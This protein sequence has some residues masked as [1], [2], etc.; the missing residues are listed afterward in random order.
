VARR[1][2]IL[3]QGAAGPP[4]VVGRALIEPGSLFRD[5]PEASASERFEDLFTAATAAG[6]TRIERIVSTGQATPP[7]EW[8]EQAWDEWVLLVTGSATLTIV[9]EGADETPC[10]LTPG[11]HLA[12]L[13]G[14]RHRVDRTD[15]DRPTIWLAVHIGELA[16]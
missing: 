12:I 13:A 16:R 3:F 14:T 8:L 7:G 9:G 4:H 10:T 5:L 2:P 1:Q 11:D 15:P 6:A